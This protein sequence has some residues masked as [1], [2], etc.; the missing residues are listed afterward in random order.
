VIKIKKAVGQAL[1]YLPVYGVRMKDEQHRF[2]ML[3]GQFPGRLTAEQ[4]AWLLNCQTH[5]MPGL[6]AAR[7][8]KP[9]GNPPPNGI[10]FFATAD[11][12]EL[13]KDRSRLVKITIAIND[14][15]RKMNVNKRRRSMV[16]TE[17]A[18]STQRAND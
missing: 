3:S 13:T 9:L 10:K 5:D 4:T 12:I 7:L 11:I 15:W 18:N 1:S 2:L 16:E 17:S 14:H 8:I 6:I